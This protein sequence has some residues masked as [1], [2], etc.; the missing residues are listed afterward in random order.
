MVLR[1]LGAAGI[2]SR[3]LK[4]A[5]NCTLF[6]NFVYEIIQPTKENEGNKKCCFLVLLLGGQEMSKK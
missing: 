5:F 4:D 2:A 3:L 6:P 1:S